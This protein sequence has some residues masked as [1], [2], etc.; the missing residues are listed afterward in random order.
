MSVPSFVLS[1]DFISQKQDTAEEIFQNIEYEKSN[2]W[3]DNLKKALIWGLENDEDILFFSF[4]G[5]F[6]VKI[7]TEMLEES[8]LQAAVKK[9]YFLYLDV[10]SGDKVPIDKSFSLVLEIVYVKSFIIM[11]PLYNYIFDILDCQN[12]DHVDPISI[13]K[14]ICPFNFLINSDHYFFP[15]EEHKIHILSPFR[16]AEKYIQNCLDSLLIQNYNNYK[17]YFLDDNSSDYGRELIPVHDKI[18]L[19]YNEDRKFALENIITA[20]LDNTFEDDDIICIVDGDDRLPHGGVFEIVNAFYHHFDCLITYGSLTHFNKIHKHGGKYGKTDFE[21]VRKAPWHYY[22][23]RTFKYKVFKNF[24]EQD[25]ELKQLKSPEDGSFIHMPY[26]MGI[27][28]NFLEIVG[29]DKIQFIDTPL[30]EY[31]GH[32]NN[33]ANKNRDLQIWGE[34]TFRNKGSLAMVDFEK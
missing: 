28:F 16:N 17:L 33:D 4:N 19:K 1:H 9:I 30:Y 10:E 3:L 32:D 34:K 14:L 27:F 6:D 21:N 23:L 12:L 13:F 18:S 31:R 26:D 7:D 15:Q 29:F 8:I 24:L 2:S 20:L 11:K 22:P 25:P 5:Q